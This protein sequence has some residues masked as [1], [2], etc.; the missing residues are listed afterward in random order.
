MEINIK[1]TINIFKVVIMC[2]YLEKE[3]PQVTI[4]TIINLKL[5]CDTLT[6]LNDSPHIAWVDVGCKQNL[7][8]KIYVHR[9][10]KRKIC[11]A[12]CP[13]GTHMCN[14]TW[15][16]QAYWSLREN[17]I[18]TEL[19]NMKT[20]RKKSENWTALSQT[21]FIWLSFDKFHLTS[22]NFKQKIKQ[23]SPL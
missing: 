23:T 5:L 4:W 9:E 17:K 11:H 7:C 14:Y 15:E 3:L 10:S 2:Y 18:L 22:T 1:G 13:Q 16:N 12:Q 20:A 19:I 8:L 6:H 21:D